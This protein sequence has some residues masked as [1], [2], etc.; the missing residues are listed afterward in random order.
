MLK[1]Y[2]SYFVAY[3]VDNIGKDMNNVER[4]I[5]FGS[6]ARDEGTKESDIDIFIE[7]KKKTKNTEKKIK[8]V[9][10]D[11]YQSREAMLFKAKGIENKINIKLGKLREWEELYKSIASTGI[12]LYGPYEIKE[13]PSGVKQYTIIFWDKIGKNRGAFLNKIYGFKIKNK[14]YV[15]LLSKF[16]GKRIGK[17][18]IMLPTQ[19]KRDIFR[20]LRAYKVRAKTIEIF[21]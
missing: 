10:Q 2:A 21:I 15:G 5:L 8:K 1:A 6:V 7:L 18:C 19:Y 14:V 3:F 9:L 20:L 12:I 4:I 11:F 16:N 17:S 13:L